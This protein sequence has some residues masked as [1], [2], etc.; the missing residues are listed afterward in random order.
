MKAH[1]ESVLQ[2]LIQKRTE[3]IA[4][5]DEM[6]ST[7]Q[8][9]DRIISLYEIQGAGREIVEKQSIPQASVPT[10]RATS[11]K[12]LPIGFWTE[13]FIAALDKPAKDSSEAWE[14]I[15]AKHGLGKEK[16]ASFTIS[17]ARA[18][19]KGELIKKTAAGFT[20]RAAAKASARAAP[21]KVAQ[22]SGDERKEKRGDGNP[23][24]FG[25]WNDAIIGAIKAGATTTTDIWAKIQQKHSLPVKK[26]QSLYS[27]LTLAHKGHI[28]ERGDHGT[29]RL[30][31]QAAA[32]NGNAR[33]S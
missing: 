15:A 30:G 32:L 24:P 6:E 1:G 21:P 27:S 23:L 2:S 12:D 33:T 18:L 7:I 20:L 19:K 25:F 16:R 3:L 26:R 9:L 13:A 5:R 31:K 8:S 4:A 14:R 10:P 29:L 17:W 28:I 22:Q 11:Q